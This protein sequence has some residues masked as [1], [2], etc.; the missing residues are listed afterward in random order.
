MRLT[1]FYSCEPI[2]FRSF[3]LQARPA[4]NQKLVVEALKPLE[5]R[6]LQ[7]PLEFGHLE[8]T[9][10]PRKRDQQESVFWISLRLRPCSYGACRRAALACIDHKF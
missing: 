7:R 9:K 4:A 3:L 8:G 5:G 6:C 2:R 1:F 10:L